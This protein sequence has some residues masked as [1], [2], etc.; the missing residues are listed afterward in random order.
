ML[1]VITVAET[2]AYIAIR[3]EG[4]AISAS[5][6]RLDDFLK[7]AGEFSTAAKRVALVLRD[8][9][10]STRG[11]RSDELYESLSLDLVALTEGSPAAVAFLERSLGQ[12]LM[13]G[14]D[15]GTTPIGRSYKAWSR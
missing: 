1:E 10:S 9:K 8:S 5:R 11:R 15:S 4:P 2:D 3:V 12:K 7:I 6:M 13:P 14:I